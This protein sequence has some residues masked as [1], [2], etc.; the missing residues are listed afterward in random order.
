T[1]EMASS[2][3]TEKS[4]A[5]LQW[6]LTP[7]GFCIILYGLNII[8]WGGMLFL[9]LCNAAPAMCHPSCDAPSSSR[10]IWIEI[11]SQILNALFCITGFGLAPWRIRDMYLWCLWRLRGRTG[12]TRLAKVHDGWFVLDAQYVALPVPSHF[13]VTEGQGPTPGLSTP[14]WKLDVV[15]WG[16]MLNSILQ[17]CLAVCM[18]AWNRFD[19]PGW[20]TGLFVCL[21]C[22]ASGVAGVVIWL[23]KRRVGRLKG[24]SGDAAFDGVSGASDGRGK[25]G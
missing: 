15:V 4:Q 18:W 16:N 17:V 1:T 24:G 3:W 22:L 21:A 10:R 14:L 25:V 20:M 5:C 9:L 19:R 13:A 23:E 6:A 11:D 8:A 2:K 7:L 12:L